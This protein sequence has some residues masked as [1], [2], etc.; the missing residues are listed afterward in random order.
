MGETGCFPHANAPGR[1][2]T[3]DPR[4]RS[5]PLCPLSYRRQPVG[6]AKRTKTACRVRLGHEPSDAAD[7]S[8]GDHDRAVPGRR[9]QDGQELRGPR[10]QGLLRRH[11]LPP[12]DRGLHDPGR[13]P[14]GT[15]T[16]A[17]AIRSRTAQRAPRRPRRARDGQRRPEH[18]RQPVLHRHSGT[19]AVAGWKAHGFGRVTEGMDVVDE[20]SRVPKDARTCRTSRL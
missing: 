20:I 19:S 8:R 15:G 1:I 3:S 7:K 13:L 6:F 10:P 16:V 14:Q 9:P 4:I 5:P 12:G 2:R 11:H 18:E 17:P